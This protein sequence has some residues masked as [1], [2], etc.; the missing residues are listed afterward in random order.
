MLE[1]Y[2]PWEKALQRF[3]ASFKQWFSAAHNSLYELTA[4]NDYLRH[5]SWN[6]DKE[7]LIYLY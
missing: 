4:L 5:S 6:L 7:G 1:G 3:K 2:R